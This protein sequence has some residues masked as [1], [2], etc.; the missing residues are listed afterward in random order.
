MSQSM[1]CMCMYTCS[2]LGNSLVMLTLHEIPSSQDIE[3]ILITLHI[4]A[5]GLQEIPQNP[6]CPLLSVAD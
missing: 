2:G 5:L 4:V 3:S 1:Y 6:Y